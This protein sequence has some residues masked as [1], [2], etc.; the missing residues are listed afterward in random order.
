MS[1]QTCI[2]T[3]DDF[4]E[5]YKSQSHYRDFY[6]IE[7][8]DS[9]YPDPCQNFQ[10][11]EQ[12]SDDMF[13]KYCRGDSRYCNP[14]IAGDILYLQF[15]YPIIGIGNSPLGWNAGGTWGF[16]MEI[17][18]ENGNIIASDIAIFAEDYGIGWDE[19]YESQRQ[20]INID[21]LQFINYNSFYVHL[22]IKDADGNVYDYLS[23]KYCQVQC[24]EETILLQADMTQSDFD[25]FWYSVPSGGS[26]SQN[27]INYINQ[28][29]VYGELVK[30]NNEIETTITNGV[31]TK[32]KKTPQYLLRINKVPE[33]IADKI[34]LLM[35]SDHITGTYF[36]GV[37]EIIPAVE[38]KN[39]K[40][41]SKEFD[42]GKQWLIEVVLNKKTV[43]LNINCQ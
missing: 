27:T 19:N 21:T 39:P 26:Y 11:C 7:C 36:N 18:D 8:S 1:T 6:V 30:N 10:L 24:N 32:I 25:G 33:Y 15:Q 5:D 12:S 9:P 16:D 37:N 43:E 17:L 20:W 31:L 22:M 42:E 28:I 2:V 4:S 3:V 41:I 14:F 23:D 35:S 13:K 38:F 34:A 40:Q 29:R